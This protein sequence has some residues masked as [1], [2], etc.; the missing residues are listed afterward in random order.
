M[1]ID[2]YYQN[3]CKETF[4]VNGLLA[5]FSTHCPQNFNYAYDVID[6]IATAEPGRRAMVWCNECGE[7]RILTFGEIKRYSDMTANLLRAHGIRQGDM[8]MLALKRHYQFWF[9]ILALH[10]LGAVAI[11]SASMLTKKDLCYRFE[12]AGISAVICTADG[13]LAGEVDA[14]CAGLPDMKAKFLVAGSA[15]ANAARSGW[16][17]YN[18]ALQTQSANWQRIDTLSTDPA[19]LYFTS[20]T[21]GNPKMA[22]HDHTYPLGHILSAKYWHNIQPD[23]LHLTVADTGW[24]KA[25]WGKIYGQWFLGA[26]LFVYDFNRFVAADLMQMIEKYH[27]TTFCAPPTIYRFLIKEDLSQYDLSSIRHATT[28]G[29]ALNAEVFRKFYEH[30]GLRIME[31]FGQTETTA[32][33]VNLAGSAPRPGSMGRPSP[34]YRLELVDTDGTPVPD[35]EEGEL[36]VCLPDG[37]K[38]IGLFCG[39]YK[40]AEQTRKVWHDGMYHTGDIAWR[41]TDGYLWYVGRT[42][43]V[44]KASGYRIGP[45]EIESVLMEHPAVLECAVTGAADPVRGTVVKATVVLAGGYSASDML[46]N[47]LQSYVKKQ[48]APYKYPRIVEF[49]DC[50]PKTFSGKIKRCDIRAGDRAR[51]AA[52]MPAMR[53]A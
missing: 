5:T 16:V 31:A 45:F 39:Y 24:A 4:D 1:N 28:A 43:D 23:S 32:L 46:A 22:L 41:D 12:A 2:T 52:P 53:R 19:L 11:N 15:G 51:A 34:L 49:V 6:V 40:N 47:E 13:D 29:E 33:T 21:T 35:G 36:V 27:I 20:G 14:A 42:D 18:H 7:E 8:V 26:S 9:C 48:T 38:Q 17:D 50:L 10:K 30:T 25:S 37:G 3:F 44:I